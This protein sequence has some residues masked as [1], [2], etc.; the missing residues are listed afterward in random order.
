MAMAILSPMR[1]RCALVE[2]QTMAQACL[3][4]PSVVS[5]AVHP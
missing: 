4:Y 5:Q 2:S 3:I 1:V